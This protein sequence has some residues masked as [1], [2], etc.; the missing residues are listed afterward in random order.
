MDGHGGTAASMKVASELPGLLSNELVVNRR[1]VQDA[2]QDSW[3]TICLSYR[4]QCSGG[5]ECAAEYDS[6]EGILFANTGSEDLVAGTTI[7]A[8][9]LDEKTGKLTTMNCGDSRS[10]VVNEKGELKFATRDHT[11]KEELERLEKGAEEGL[12]YS[13]PKC[14]LSKW[15]LS[16][17]DYEYSVA[18]SLEGPFA[19]SK[20]IISDPDFTTVGVEVGDILLSASD[21]LWEVMDSSEVAIDLLKMRQL[22]MPARDIAR[23]L[24][25]L[26]LRKGTPDNISAVVVLL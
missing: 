13:I 9:A 12:S 11:P 23:K 3:E 6:R 2:L 26:A 25:S 17:G 8:M 18:R 10:I 4:Q 15:W 14:R 20:G 24:C 1:S 19:T 7:S 5:E 21:G 16:V 22:G